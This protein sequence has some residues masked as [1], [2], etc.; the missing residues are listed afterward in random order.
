MHCDG[1]NYQNSLHKQSRR[2]VYQK[3]TLKIVGEDE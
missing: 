2:G 3:L 1:K